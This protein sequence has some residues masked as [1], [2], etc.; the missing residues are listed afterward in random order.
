MTAPLVAPGYA[1]QP[2]Y[3][4]ASSDMHFNHYLPSLDSQPACSPSW[5][6]RTSVHAWPENS[7]S[8]NDYYNDPPDPFLSRY[9]PIPS[10]RPIDSSFSEMI[11]HLPSAPP[12]PLQPEIPWSSIPSS[13]SNP[14]PPSTPRLRSP[15]KRTKTTESFTSCYQTNSSMEAKRAYVVKKELA[16]VPEP[17]PLS[18]TRRPE[19]SR[20]T[21]PATTLVPVER[22]CHKSLKTM[23]NELSFLADE[24]VAIT[25]VLD[26]LRNAFVATTPQDPPPAL[27]NP[28]HSSTNPVVGPMKTPVLLKA[29]AK[30][31][32]T[33]SVYT[34]DMDKEVRTAYDD[35]MMQ[36]KQLEK[37]ILRLEEQMKTVHS[38]CPSLELT[39]L[40][41]R[42]SEAEEEEEEEDTKKD[43]KKDQD[44]SH[45]GDSVLLTSDSMQE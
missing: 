23:E 32:E 25:I 33:Q 7:A 22:A 16:T 34:S 29:P 28:T 21:P 42:H 24:T 9:S 31:T 15:R 10:Y 11:N 41:R 38:K 3:M 44:T 45:C 17:V 12:P 18:P 20:S 5:T 14:L 6:T 35:L 27:H 26:S 13:L 8:F 43:T 4:N 36:V 40:K 37:K 2:F 1:Y 30:S 39:H 19:V